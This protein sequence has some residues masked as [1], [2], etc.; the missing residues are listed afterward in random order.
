M[1]PLAPKIPALPPDAPCVRALFTLTR[2]P[3]V[4][5]E[6]ASP[7]VSDALRKEL[8]PQ[9]INVSLLYVDTHVGTGDLAKPGKWYTVKYSGYLV[10]GTKF[11]SSDGRDPLT[12]PY[13]GH[14]VIAG[15]DTGFE[16][17]HVGGKRRLFIPYQLAYGEQGKPP[18]IPAR[19]QLIFD[20]EL[21][22]QSDTSPQERLKAAPKPPATGANG[23][24]ATGTGAGPGTSTPGTTAPGAPG[25]TVAPAAKPSTSPAGAAATPP[26]TSSTPA[27]S[28]QPATKPEPK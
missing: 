1:P 8:T 6:Y 16:G 9:P 15:W 10:D 18:V 2:K 25:N 24:P 26:V 12:F 7:L 17:M 4:T 28:T 23:A 11:D 27:A 3:D 21:V 22:S 20:M 19:A 13:G 5:L 14:Q